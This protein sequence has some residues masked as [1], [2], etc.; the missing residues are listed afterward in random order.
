MHEMTVAEEVLASVAR[1]VRR[2]GARKAISITLCR[3][4]YGCVNPASL[5]FCIGAIAED[6]V[7][8]GAEVKFRELEPGVLCPNCGPVAAVSED[9]V[10]VCP[11]CA[12]P[13]EALTGTELFLEM[14]ELD[15]EED[16]PPGEA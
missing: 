8:D 9:A 13:A 2:N 3:G 15:V 16:C 7:L 11:H 4:R 10:A 14:V 12:G 5:T 1:E 6:T